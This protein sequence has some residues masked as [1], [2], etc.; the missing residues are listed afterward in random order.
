MQVP[1]LPLTLQLMHR[2]L[3]VPSAQAELQH[4]PSLQ[5]PLPHWSPL[6]QA[7]PLGLRPHELFTQVLG[8]TQSASLLQVE[9]QAL[10]LQTKLPQEM[11]STGGTQEPAPSHFEAGCNDEGESHFA[12]SHGMSRSK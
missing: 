6:V 5:K 1:T 9:R 3:V 10:L 12:V 2:L 8:E 4:T 11:S 7:A